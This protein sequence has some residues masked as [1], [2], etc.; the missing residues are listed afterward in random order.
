M[1][2]NLEWTT[3]STV[4]CRDIPGGTHLTARRR[5]ARTYYNILRFVDAP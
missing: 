3:P 4:F 2:T 5:D 1:T